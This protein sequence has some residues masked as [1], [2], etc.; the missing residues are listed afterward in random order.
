MKKSFPYWYVVPVATALALI[1]LIL[2]YQHL[3]KDSMSNDSVTNLLTLPGQESALLTYEEKQWLQENGPLVYAADRN[4]PPLRFVD[5]ADQ[6]Y[7]GVVVDYINLLSLELGIEINLQPLVLPMKSE[8][9]SAL[10]E[11]MFIC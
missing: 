2:L 6:Q 10:F 11:L 8:T 3:W 7:K 1:T 9:P 5:P 4:A